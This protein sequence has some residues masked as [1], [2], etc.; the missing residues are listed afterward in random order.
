M[1]GVEAG[2]RIEKAIGSH[3]RVDFLPRREV[4]P[5][6]LLPDYVQ[7]RFELTF[8]Q[9]SSFT[10]LSTTFFIPALSNAT[11]SFDPSAVLI[12]P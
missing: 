8:A 1:V 5:K 6:V 3:A 4:S 12:V 11:V 9:G 2:A 10:K 7:K